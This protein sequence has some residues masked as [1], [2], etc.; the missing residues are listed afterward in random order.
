MIKGSPDYI[1]KQS[2]KIMTKD[3]KSIV[4]TETNKA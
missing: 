3:G 2:N 1:L 4:L